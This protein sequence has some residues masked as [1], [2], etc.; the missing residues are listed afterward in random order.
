MNVRLNWS[1][2]ESTIIKRNQFLTVAAAG[3]N[4]RSTA[5]T[6]QISLTTEDFRVTDVVTECANAVEQ[7]AIEKFNAIL[8]AT[9]GI[10]DSINPFQQTFEERIKHLKQ[11][12]AFHDC[13]FAKSTASTSN[14]YTR[15]FSRGVN[16]S[17][18]FD[19]FGISIEYTNS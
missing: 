13:V 6:E 4:D 5:F 17:A 9:A 19:F 18:C 8:N 14:N 16:S 7:R 12:I 10:R 3:P 15:T 1:R 2:N 11:S